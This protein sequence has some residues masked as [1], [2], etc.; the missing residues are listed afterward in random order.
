M[1]VPVTFV[2]DEAGYLEIGWAVRSRLRDSVVPQS[3]VRDDDGMAIWF[4]A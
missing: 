1:L 3:V 2:Q 4:L